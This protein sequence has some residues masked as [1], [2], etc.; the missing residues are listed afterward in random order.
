MEIEAPLRAEI[1]S[2]RADGVPR[3]TTS[4]MGVQGDK[5]IHILSQTIPGSRAD[6][7]PSGPITTHVLE[8]NYQAGT[9]VL[10]FECDDAAWVASV[11]AFLNGKTPADLDDYMKRTRLVDGAYVH[12]ALNDRDEKAGSRFNIS[13]AQLDLVVQRKGSARLETGNRKLLGRG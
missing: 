3:D 6:G 4:V 7:R 9:A 1:D 10:N 2:V 8:L 13:Q 5:L 12:D 11:E